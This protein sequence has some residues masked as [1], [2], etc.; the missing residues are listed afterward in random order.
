MLSV[1]RF[2][3]LF[4]KQKPPLY[5]HEW[6]C[7]VFSFVWRNSKRNRNKFNSYNAKMFDEHLFLLSSPC[8]MLQYQFTPIHANTRAHKYIQKH[9]YT[10]KCRARF[11]SI[12]RSADCWQFASH[13]VYSHIH[14]KYHN[15]AYI[16]NV[17]F[18]HFTRLNTETEHISLLSNSIHLISDSAKV[19][20]TNSKLINFIQ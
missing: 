7:L 19:H 5:S 16:Q 9:S 1:V 13:S 8:V 12:F 2:L 4:C 6:I 3:R 17:L 18:I 11:F 14:T 15:F 10:S 20:N